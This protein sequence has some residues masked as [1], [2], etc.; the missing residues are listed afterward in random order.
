MTGPTTTMQDG[1]QAGIIP[2]AIQSLIDQL[3]GFKK[4]RTSQE[5]TYDFE[6]R[7]QFLELY[8]EE[9]R[10]LLTTKASV[11]KLAMRDIGMDEPEVLGATQHKVRRM[12]RSVWLAACCAASKDPLPS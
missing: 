9:I 2:R 11:D 1:N 4:E 6:A 10:D 12:L 5:F 7:I 3:V 8:G